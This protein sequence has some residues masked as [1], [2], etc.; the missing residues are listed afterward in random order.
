MK[1]KNN[2][3]LERF[4][5]HELLS[6]FEDLGVHSSKDAATFYQEFDSGDYYPTWGHLLPVA[7]NRGYG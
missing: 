5:D 4:N 7:I 6:S 2:V 3:P 1:K